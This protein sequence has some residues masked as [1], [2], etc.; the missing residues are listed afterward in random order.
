M[1]QII[2]GLAWWVHDVCAHESF[3]E[4]VWQSVS[5]TNR[6]TK[7]ERALITAQT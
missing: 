3:E 1:N 5:E 4:R 2:C 6:V 7:W